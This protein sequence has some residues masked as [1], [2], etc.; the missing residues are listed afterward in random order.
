MYG[1]GA[2]IPIKMLLGL[3]E[4]AKRIVV[5]EPNLE[6]IYIALHL[7]DFSEDILNGRLKIVFSESFDNIGADILIADQEAKLF[8]KNYKLDI[9]SPY[10]NSFI[11]NIVHVNTVM[12]DNFKKN[13][14]GAGNDINDS[15]LGLS[16]FIY[17]LPKIPTTPTFNELSKKLANTENIVIVSTGPSLDKQLKL[18][19][20]NQDYMTIVAVDASFPILVKHGIKPDMVVTIERIELTREFYENTPSEGYEDVIVSLTSIV[21]KNLIKTIEDKMSKCKNATLQFTNRP[22][23]YQHMY[24]LSE[25]G[26][27]GTGMSAANSAFEM[28]WQSDNVKKIILIGQDL[29]YGEGG[30]THSSD[31]KLSKSEINTGDE[32]NIMLPAY[33]GEGTVKTNTIWQQFAHYFEIEFANVTAYKPEIKVINSTEGGMRIGNF[34][35]IPFKTVIDG[36]DKSRKKKVIK[37]SPPTKKQQEKLQKTV[38]KNILK[39]MKNGIKYKKRYIKVYKELMN[40]LMDLDELSKKGEEALKNID[41]NHV[42][43]ISKQIHESKLLFVEEDFKN[44]YSNIMLSIITH[45]EIKIAEIFVQKTTTEMEAKVKSIKWLYA[46]RPWLLYTLTGIFRATKAVHDAAKMWMHIDEK[47][48]KGIGESLDKDMAT[49]EKRL[50]KIHKKYYSHKDKEVVPQNKIETNMPGF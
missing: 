16:Q 22:F 24:G 11:E 35:E 36:L 39:Y 12:I 25:W 48:T 42:K 7:N 2:G 27:I 3:M 1:I 13:V 14:F 43:E 45:E 41:W 47:I 40:M 44:A 4:D 20:E 29:S 46:H 17:N 49:V 10:Y 6:L 30:S 26:K 19:K 28:A 37:L 18:L 21:H 50:G 23:S 9:L 34:E 33:G 15:L 31:Y 38:E 8:I 5:F 32:D